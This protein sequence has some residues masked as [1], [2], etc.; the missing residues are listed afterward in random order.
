[1]YTGE[2]ERTFTSRVVHVLDDSTD[3]RK[4]TSSKTYIVRSMLGF[5][6]QSALNFIIQIFSRLA[7]EGLTKKKKKTHFSIST[8][9]IF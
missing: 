2:G 4:S 1:M 5:G 8:L 3:A 6:T 9:A 7:E